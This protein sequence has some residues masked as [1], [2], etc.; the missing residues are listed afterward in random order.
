[1]FDSG[2][3]HMNLDKGIPDLRNSQTLFATKSQTSLVSI[4][5][6]KKLKPMGRSNEVANFN[7]TT[8]LKSSNLGVSDFYLKNFL[9]KQRIETEGRKDEN[10]TNLNFFDLPKTIRS[11]TI[12]NRKEKISARQIQNELA[13]ISSGY[14]LKQKF[15]D[16]LG[17][18]YKEF[19]MDKKEFMKIFDDIDVAMFCHEE[20]RSFLKEL[21]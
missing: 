11:A 19:Y 21:L 5:K 1:V 18:S 2:P 3:K 7:S 4:N 16:T 20:V 15:Y 17:A 6:T 10:A 8:G 14:G 12:E 13:Q 9:G